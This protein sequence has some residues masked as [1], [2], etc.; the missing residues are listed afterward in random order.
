[1]YELIEWVI[2]ED[3]FFEIKVLFVLELIMGFVWIYG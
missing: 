1:M 3:L 2:D